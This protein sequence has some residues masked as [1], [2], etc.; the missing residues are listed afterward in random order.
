MPTIPPAAPRRR[1]ILVVEDEPTARNALAQVLSTDYDV[2]V[3]GD[4]I[5]GAEAAQR[6]QPDLIVTDVNMPRLDG[7]EMVRRIRAKSGWK[8]PVIFLTALDSP[9]DVIAGIA[10][11]ARH[12]LTKP[13]DISDLE[14]RVARVLGLE[15]AI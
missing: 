3:A 8:I 12:Y 7:R 4:G 11:G 2:T 1:R 6:I 5:E 15:R 9:A 13:V 10:A 14:Q